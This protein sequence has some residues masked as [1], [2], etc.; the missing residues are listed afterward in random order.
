MNI[1]KRVIC[2]ML[3][4]LIS[5]CDEKE[6]VVDKYPFDVDYKYSASVVYNYMDYYLKG[7][8]LVKAI[9]QNKGLVSIATT[10]P[11]NTS[12]VSYFQLT[13]LDTSYAIASFNQSNQTYVNLRYIP[14]GM[15]TYVEYKVD[16]YNVLNYVGARLVVE[17]VRYEDD[18]MNFEKAYGISLK[19]NQFVFKIIEIR[20]LG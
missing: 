1:F 4:I 20:P 13:M 16:D 10:N 12:N 3:V 19:D 5:G 17:L 14:F 2:L 11:D 9:N 18:I 6:C 8:K 7:D 15:I